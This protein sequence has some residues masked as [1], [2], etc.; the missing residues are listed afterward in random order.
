M[1]WNLEEKSK[2]LLVIKDNVR[3]FWRFCVVENVPDYLTVEFWPIFAV[4][5]TSCCFSFQCYFHILILGHYFYYISKGELKPSM[6]SRDI[7]TVRDNL[8]KICWCTWQTIF[9]NVV[10]NYS[11]HYYSIKGLFQQY[12]FQTKQQRIN[13]NTIESIEMLIYRSLAVE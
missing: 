11:V 9:F 12:Y 3:W 7:R 6:L 8:G 4:C 2:R 10:V 5:P 13:S 1:I